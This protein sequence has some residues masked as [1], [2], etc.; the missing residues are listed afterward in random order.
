MLNDNIK[1]SIVCYFLLLMFVFLFS[2][3]QTTSGIIGRAV[4]EESEKDKKLNSRVIFNNRKM[5]RYVKIVDMK[6]DFAY[7]LMNASV[8]LKSCKDKTINIQYKFV[9]YNS[10]GIEI[11]P[12]SLPWIP[13]TIYGKETKTVQSV[14][15]NPS[16]KEF[17]IK[18]RFI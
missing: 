10:K 15:P 12:D 18:L 9:W 17:K 4:I 6:S 1:K 11:D 14:A 5:K 7:N 13:L 16:A 8:T 2:A 3:C